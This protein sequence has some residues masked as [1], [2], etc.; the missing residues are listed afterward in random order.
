MNIGIIGSSGYIGS[1]L[2]DLLSQH[3]DVK[4]YDIQPSTRADVVIRGGD[5]TADDLAAHDVIIYLA[6]L[7]GRVQCNAHTVAEV[8]KENVEDIC[9]VAHKL[10]AKQMLI[11]ASSASVVEGN[12]ELCQTE[13]GEV[14][15][16]SLDSYANSMYQRELR[17]AAAG[18]VAAFVGLRFGTVIGISPAQRHDLVHIAMMA[19]ALKTNKLTIQNP[20]CH[21]GILAL[22]DL[23]RAIMAMLVFRVDS[24]IYHLASFNTT[25]REI[26][27]VIAQRTGAEV[28][29]VEGG[30]GGFCLDTTKFRETYGFEFH[31]TNES[32]AAELQAGLKGT[33]PC[34]VCKGLTKVIIDLG[35]HALANNYVETPQEQDAFPLVLT[36]CEDCT[37]TQLNYTVPPEVMFSNYQYNSGTSKTLCSYFSWLADDIIGDFGGG[38][39]T[40]FELACNDGSQLDEFKKRGWRTFGM[41]PA[42]NIVDIALANGHK[43]TVGFWGH[44]VAAPEMGTPDAIVAQNVVAHVPDPVLFL[45]ACADIMGPNTRLYIQ[46][47]QCDM[48]KNGEFDTIYHEHLSF[49][50]ARS[51]KRAAELAGLAIIH[52]RK[53][54]IHGD[55]FLFTMVR[56]SNALTEFIRD[57]TDGGYLAKYTSRIFAIRRWMAQQLTKF[58]EEGYTIVAYGAA[59]KGMTLMNFMNIYQHIEYIVDDAPMKQGR[60][61]AGTNLPIRAPGA[62]QSDTRKLAIIVLAW[63][64]AAEIT[65][66]IRGIRGDGETVLIY[67]FPEQT[68]KYL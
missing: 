3:Y 26:G 23:G 25:I 20:D 60:F 43:V 38:L 42:R 30:A 1:Y 56:C 68:V 67:P 59:A 22:T 29:V 32:L 48:Y 12:V 16:E 64:F 9:S 2:Y 39:G 49:F 54:P 62:I 37:H 34:R 18:G 50:T 57:E 35:S 46:T 24:G 15:P 6:G 14:R 44:D 33:V 10:S 52:A 40:V 65:E 13:A 19:A 11:Y 61:T 63:N 36:R 41:D 17:M 45:K 47:S 53:T 7:S 31:G 27:E 58:K 51:M 21:R 66:R 4:G 28:Q 8:L 5:I 55:S